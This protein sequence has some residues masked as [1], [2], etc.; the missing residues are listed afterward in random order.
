MWRALFLA[1]GFYVMLVGFQCLGVE[2][3]T[4]RIHDDAPTDGFTWFASDEPKLGP[5]R[6]IAVPPWAPWSLLS[7]G[8]VMCLYSFTVSQRLGAG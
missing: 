6:Q 7:T 5:L 8:A 2:T 1:I 3:I 4:L